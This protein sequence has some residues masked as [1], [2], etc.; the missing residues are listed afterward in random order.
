M[1]SSFILFP[2]LII[3]EI[4]E[5]L[6]D[7]FHHDTP[8]VG[9]FNYFKSFFDSRMRFLLLISRFVLCLLFGWLFLASV[10]WSIETAWTFWWFSAVSLELA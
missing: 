9:D 1:F 10:T 4:I 3:Y 8:V 7:L 2:V 5:S 6:L